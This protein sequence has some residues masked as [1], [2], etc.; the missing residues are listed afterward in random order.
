MR[1]I[2]HKPQHAFSLV[3]LL[4]VIA[5]V[6]LLIGLLL[7]SLKSARQAACVVRAHAD[8]RTCTQVLEVYQLDHAGAL[9][10]TRFSCSDGTAFPLPLELARKKYLPRSGDDERAV[11]FPDV[12]GE[13]ETYRYRAPGPAWVNE[14]MY[15]ADGS[16]LYVPDDAPICA[17]ETGDYINVPRQS[18]VRYAVW[19]IGPEAGAAKLARYANRLPLP[20]WLWLGAGERSGVI[21]HFQDHAGRLFQS[22]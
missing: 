13:G 12:F 19:S 6:A 22:P 2:P 14:T 10:P 21:T 18:P 17:A 15:V 4:V 20:R 9:P 7:P 5:L 3:E 1:V 16:Y 8:L 11:H